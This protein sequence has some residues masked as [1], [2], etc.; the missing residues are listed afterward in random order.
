MSIESDLDGYKVVSELGAALRERE[1]LMP[2]YLDAEIA[3]WG[4]YQA[5]LAAQTDEQV[6][7]SDE[8]ILHK[9]L[10]A[11]DVGD[12]LWDANNRIN[13]A[14]SHLQNRTGAAARQ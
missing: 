1:D 9:E 10:A 13:T 3:V 6:V 12:K 14:Y 4:A 8:L 11:S 2:Y 5:R 7:L